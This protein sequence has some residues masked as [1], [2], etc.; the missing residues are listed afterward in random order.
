MAISTYAELKTAVA[1]WLHDSNLTTRIPEFIA[2]AEDRINQRVR[3]KAM[4]VTLPLRLAAVVDGGTVGGTGDAI[5]L[6]PTTAAT[7]YN[8]G[9]AYKC[10]APASNTGA[11]TV[12][13][14]GLGVKNIKFLEGGI[15]RD[16][17]A[18]EILSGAE[19][20]F[21]YDGTSFLIVPQGGI[22]LPLRYKKTR[23][24]YLDGNEKRLDFMPSTTFWTRRA[25]NESNRPKVYTIEGDFIIFAPVPDAEIVGR[26]LYYRGFAAMS[27]DGDTNWI[28]QNAR[29]LLLYGALVEASPYLRDDPRTLTW[30]A[31]FDQALEDIGEEDRGDRYPEGV[32]QMISDVPV[33]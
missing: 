11:A 23:R 28:L 20:R 29:G 12:N 9:D 26:H 19:L 31:L 16:P 25:V 8:Y 3:V 32:L 30:A 18:N 7:A 27:A 4:E 15:Q 33:T 6:T 21:F 1:N 2:L 17:A 13:I 5:T 10:D 24:I 22:P 14:S